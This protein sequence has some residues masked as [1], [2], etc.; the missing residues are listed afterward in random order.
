MLFAWIYVSYKF[1]EKHEVANFSKITTQLIS[2][3]PLRYS[4]YTVGAS[5]TTSAVFL[6]HLIDYY[7]NSVKIYQNVL[8]IV[9]SRP[10]F[11]LGLF[12]VILPLML[13]RGKQL[14]GFLGAPFMAP[15]SKLTYGVYMYHIIFLST[16]AFTTHSYIF[17]SNINAFMWV[18]HEYLFS[19]IM[20]LLTALLI[21]AP[22]IRIEKAMISRGAAKPI[23]S[24]KPVETKEVKE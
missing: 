19:L 8:F 16:E 15:L 13:G 17:F 4:V 5:L 7:C 1:K 14:S 22:F 6:Q 18:F 11:I 20:S 9:L 2:N 21:E 24:Y 12:L 3:K 10:I 23:T